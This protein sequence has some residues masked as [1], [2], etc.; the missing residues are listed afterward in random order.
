MKKY[1]MILLALLVLLTVFT[2]VSGQIYQDNLPRV[3]A[4]NTFHT[5]LRYQWELTGSVVHKAAVSYYA[6]V[7]VEIAARNVETGQ[8]VAAGTPLLQVDTDQLHVQWLRC[9]IQQETLTG[10]LETSEAYERELL[11]Y[12]LAALQ[13]TVS[14]I[15]AL[16]K[17]SGWIYA[18]E[19][20]VILSVSQSETVGAEGLLARL[21]P[22]AGTKQLIFPM[23]QKQASY[24]TE[25]KALRVKLPQGSKSTAVDMKPEEVYYDTV[26]QTWQC[27]IETREPIT[28]PD[29]QGIS[30]VFSPGSPVYMS[31]IPNSAIVADNNGSVTFYVL[32]QKETTI[33]VEYYVILK[34]GQV[35]EQ[36][37]IYTALYEPVD[38]PVVFGWSEPLSNG[39]TVRLIESAE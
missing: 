19:P 2:Y 17:A 12:Q 1:G 29:G 26:Q 23:T 7:S 32:K 39:M 34:T 37:D 27:I 36:D 38:D 18:W 8:W 35:L 6:P 20:G 15:E 9:K 11:E 28:V 3:M 24:C 33:G 22:D 13:Q 10:Q 30:A 4:E 21:G 14:Q 25:G 16:E 5:Q 31:V